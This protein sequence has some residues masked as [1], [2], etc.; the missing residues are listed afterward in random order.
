MKTD[1]DGVMINW[2]ELIIANCLI[3]FLLFVPTFSVVCNFGEI[4]R[5][6]SRLIEN[7]YLHG[8][9]IEQLIQED[10]SQ[11]NTIQQLGI[12]IDSL[13]GYV[14]SLDTAFFEKT[15]EQYREHVRLESKINLLKTKLDK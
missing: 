7:S 8:E 11:N 13:K 14:E 10:T 5:S 6:I 4:N 12:N 2:K 15:K 9:K 1:R 3:I